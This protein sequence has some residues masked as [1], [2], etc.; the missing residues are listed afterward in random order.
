M[1][2]ARPGAGRRAGP[3]P[4]RQDQGDP[5]PER[6]P[7]D[8]GRHVRRVPRP[9][10]GEGGLQH[11]ADGRVDQEHE[12]RPQ[13]TDQQDRQQRGDAEGGHVDQLVQVG[14]LERRRR[15]VVAG[16]VED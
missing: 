15:D 16:E 9:P 4:A 11:L 2:P 7:D 1:P 14:D 8:V 6:H 10:L 3:A 12:R 5:R 13:P